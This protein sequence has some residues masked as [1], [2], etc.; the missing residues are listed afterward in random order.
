[1]LVRAREHHVVTDDGGVEEQF[2]VI[3]G[4]G[5]KAR[6]ALDPVV[7]LVAHQEVEAVAAQ[8]EVV[9]QASEHLRVVDADEEDVLARAAHQ[10]VEAVGVGDDVVAAFALE[11]VAR[12]AAVG[13]DVVAVAAVDQVDARAGFDAVVSGPAP[14][15]I[16][17]EIG[18]DGVVAVRTADRDVFATGEAQ[19]VLI[20]AGGQR[21]V[22]LYLAA[23]QALEHG[24][25]ACRVRAKLHGGVDLQ[26]KVVVSEGIHPKMT[27]DHIV[28]GTANAVRSRVRQGGVLHDQLGK[29]VFFQLVEEVQ[30][31]GSGQVVE[32]VAVL[33]ILQL[34]LEDG[35]EG[36]TQHA[37]EGHFLFRQPADPEVDSVDAGG[38][39][40]AV[41]PGDPGRPFACRFAGHAEDQ[42]PGRRL[43]GRRG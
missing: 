21:I 39:R 25:V 32:A 20:D 10:D 18:E 2:R 6:A 11:E 35:V 41:Q 5:V 24:V 31:L 12:V 17:A 42:I 9:A 33:E 15:G 16:V 27:I 22:A 37:A 28:A 43:L 36:R 3:A 19:E 30:A 38:R 13:D 34:S 8:D 14:D 40:R 29:G 7:A 1:M 4:G 23:S 26:V